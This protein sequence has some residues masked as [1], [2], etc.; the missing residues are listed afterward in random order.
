MHKRVNLVR[1]GNHMPQDACFRLLGKL[2]PS[3]D[4]GVAAALGR[5]LV[6][7]RRPVARERAAKLLGIRSCPQ[8]SPGSRDAMTSLCGALRDAVPSVRRAALLSIRKSGLATP[9]DL[10][11]LPLTLT[12][13]LTLPHHRTLTIDCV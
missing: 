5:A 6:A 4:G 10:L 12:I 7:A 2:P 9:G 3:R 1:F 8:G 13:T 11:T